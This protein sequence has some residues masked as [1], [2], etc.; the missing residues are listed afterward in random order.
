MGPKKETLLRWVNCCFE[1]EIPIDK[2]KSKQQFGFSKDDFIILNTNRNNYRKAIDKTIDAFIMFLKLKYCDP[3]IKLFLNML[4]DS[5]LEVQ[6]Y[7]IFNLIK[8]KQIICLL[9]NL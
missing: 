1:D 5:N 9:I 4:Y 6:G 7:D 2:I 8:I 3:R